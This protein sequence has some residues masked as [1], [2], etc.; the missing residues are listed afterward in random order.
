[1][2][3][4]LHFESFDAFEQ[5]CRHI[6]Q[7]F[8]HAFVEGVARRV[9]STP[10]WIQSQ[11]TI[12]RLLALYAKKELERRRLF[13]GF[14]S[15]EGRRII[16]YGAHIHGGQKTQSKA[17][18]KSLAAH[19]NEKTANFERHQM[20]PSVAPGLRWS[21]KTL[22]PPCPPPKPMDSGCFLG[23]KAS[24]FATKPATSSDLN[25]AKCGPST[26]RVNLACDFDCQFHLGWAA[27][28][29]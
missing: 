6:A 8:A 20:P 13:C 27:R 15:K 29:L 24:L 18:V 21:L 11:Q 2:A 25:A 5:S 14:R 22:K 9:R 26:R 7:K 28:K 10:G 23:P 17:A 16:K 3:K 12:D 4:R 1:M 19:S